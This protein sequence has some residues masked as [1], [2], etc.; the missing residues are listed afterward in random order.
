MIDTLSGTFLGVRT[1][2]CASWHN[3]SQTSRSTLKKEPI[4]RIGRFVLSGGSPVLHKIFL[5][6]EE[7]IVLDFVFDP[8]L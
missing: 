4:G 5:D 1:T 6:D 3:S 2:R 7:P 8:L